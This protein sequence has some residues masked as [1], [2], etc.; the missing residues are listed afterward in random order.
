MANTANFETKERGFRLLEFA[1]FNNLRVVNTFCPHKPSRRWTW[2]SPGGEYHNQIY[3]IMVKRHF[4]SSVNIAKTSFPG[5]DIGSDHELVMMTF[6]LH[7]QRM[8][9]QGKVRIRF[10]IEELKDPNIENSRAKIEGKF[11]P[12]LVFDDQDTEKD[13][14]INSFNIAVTETANNILG[15]H[16]PAKKP[17]DN[18]LKLCDK[19]R[20]LEQKKNTAESVKLHREANQQ[21]KKGTR[22]A[23]ETWIEEQYQGIEQKP[24]EKQ[25]HESLPACERTDKLKTRENYY[26]PGQSREMSHRRTRH[27]IEVDRVLL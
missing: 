23:M 19:G 26:H 17:W 12:P 15:K 3:Y 22:T 2:H 27:S 13:A 21:I 7:L 20:E 1:S 16:R 25:Q 18:I 5:A 10:S 11:A 6:R 9:N 24:A 4:Q 8:K 14:S